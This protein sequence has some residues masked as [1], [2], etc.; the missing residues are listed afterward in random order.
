MTNLSATELGHL[1]QAS[2][3]IM[4]LARRGSIG[5]HILSPEAYNVLEKVVNMEIEPESE[6]PAPVQ[7]EPSTETK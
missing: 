1:K 6:V 7:A 4:E 5:P 3:V 2:G